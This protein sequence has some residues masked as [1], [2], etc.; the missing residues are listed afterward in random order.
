MVIKTPA[1]EPLR[2]GERLN[3][4]EFFA[5]YEAMP[6]V[7]KCELI[8]GVV[9]MGSPVSV[10]HS[11]PHGS[12][13]GW[14][15]AYRFVTPGLALG[16]NGTVR[17]GDDDQPQPDLYLRIRSRGTC[18]TNADRYVVG[19][20]EFVCEIARSS[21]DRDTGV[22]FEMYR[23]AGVSEYLVWRVDD[24]AFDWWRLR[25]GIYEALPA[26]EAGIIRSE[27]FPGL[28]LD[29]AAMLR[30]DCPKILA[31]LQAGLASPEH[32]AFVQKLTTTSGG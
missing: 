16:D 4:A 19:P 26:D 31:T 7:K 30:D 27:V 17:L 1:L 6:D 29:T 8:Q 3:A 15:G 11:E 5:R 12:L 25:D 10:D 28:W 21:V 32:A 9:Y 2:D 20:P 18:E 23:E 14:L 13:A 24:G 22:R